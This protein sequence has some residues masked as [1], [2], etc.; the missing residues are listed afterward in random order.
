MLAQFA[1]MGNVYAKYILDIE[2]PKVGIL[3]IGEE[4]GKGNALVKDTY[5][6][7][8]ELHD[9]GRIDFVG[10]IEGKELFVNKADV[11]VTDG[12]AGNVALKVTEG[13]ASMLLKMI[14][15]EFKSNIL[16]CIIGL[17]AKPFLR[18][19]Y[20]RINWEGFGGMLLLG[21]KGISVIAHG[22]SSSFAM[23]NAVRVAAT[24][25]NNDINK[26]IAENIN[27]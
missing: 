20:K 10:N 7:L 2:K 12:F 23:K 24:T 18:N 17:L 5:P 21:V 19:M 26:K 22:R 6:L 16:G 27:R 8:K 4:E 25:L 15:R 1:Q 11:V 14:A 3:S 9:Q 13:T